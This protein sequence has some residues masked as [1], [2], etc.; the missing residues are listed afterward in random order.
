MRERR[1]QEM[2]CVGCNAYTSDILRDMEGG[3][4]AQSD[5][6]EIDVEKSKQ[7]EVKERSLPVTTVTHSSQSLQKRPILS[8]DIP[9][10][11]SVRC[12]EYEQLL[13]KEMDQMKSQLSSCPMIESRIQMVRYMK[14]CAECLHSIYSLRP[15]QQKDE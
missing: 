4:S 11:N 12:A 13:W 8:A 5:S 15:N 3:N 7:S 10:E 9:L 6:K 1:N 2:F 14:E